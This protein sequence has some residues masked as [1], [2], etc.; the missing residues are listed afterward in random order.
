MVRRVVAFALAGCAADASPSGSSSGGIEAST[1]DAASTSTSTSSSTSIGSSS[2]DDGSTP[3]ADVPHVVRFFDI[4]PI[5]AAHCVTD[6]HS[7]GGEYPELDLGPSARSNLVLVASA[8]S[9]LL[10]VSAGDHEAS[11]LWHKI[12][13]TQG[14]VGG[15]GTRM[16]E[17]AEPLAQDDI[18][19]I[20][21]W[22]DGGA[23]P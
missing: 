23:Q 5:F 4:Q 11:Y 12:N 2:E 19:L 9:S 10:L 17:G 15:M 22:I 21:A 7:P 16:P 13:G 20:A 3:P 18:D 6:C 14:E 1:S 8:G